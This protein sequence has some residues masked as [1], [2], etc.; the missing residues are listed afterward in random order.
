MTGKLRFVLVALLALVV[1]SA[2]RKS[3]IGPSGPTIPALGPG[4]LG[5]P[6]VTEVVVTE[7]GEATYVTIP[8]VNLPDGW[9]TFYV[10]GFNP[11]GRISNI[12]SSMGTHRSLGVEIKTSV[13]G[14]H[15]VAILMAGQRPWDEELPLPTERP[16]VLDYREF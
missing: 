3:P 7:Q 2:C 14:N 4:T 15:G 11:D 5:Q 16:P 10:V 13:W 12:I 6:V 8:I 1:T 9:V